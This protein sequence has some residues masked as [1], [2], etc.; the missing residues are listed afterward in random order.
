LIAQGVEEERQRREHA[1]DDE[2]K[3]RTELEKCTK[4]RDDA[5]LEI[6]KDQAEYDKQSSNY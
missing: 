6:N 4:G 3:L 2:E 5:Y 1:N